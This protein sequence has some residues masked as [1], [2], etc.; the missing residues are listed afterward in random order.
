MTGTVKVREC[1]INLQPFQFTTGN[2][3]KFK[4]TYLE[5]LPKTEYANWEL[6]G[7]AL[8]CIPEAGKAAPSVTI[9]EVDGSVPVP[10]ALLAAMAELILDAL[11]MLN[12]S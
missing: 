1:I 6:R 8:H 9:W 4:S 11:R 7:T 2:I 12:I 3:F 5:G 10:A